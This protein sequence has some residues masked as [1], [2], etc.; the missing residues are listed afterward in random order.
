M[1]ARELSGEIFNVG[2]TERIR[3]ID[4]A[5]RVRKA[6]GSGSEIVFVPYDQVYG[7]GIEDTLHRE[8]AI[9]KIGKAIG[10]APSR[11]LDEIIADVVEHRRAAAPVPS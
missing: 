7:G 3:I 9:G 1:A 4:L 11:G 8:P 2:S 5:E 10:W 6:T